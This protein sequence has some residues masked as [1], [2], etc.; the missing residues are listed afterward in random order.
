MTVSTYLFVD[1]ENLDA[2]LGMSVLGRRPDPDERPRWD[3]VLAYCDHLSSTEGE[4]GARALFFLNATSGHM[5][6]GFIQALLAMD[7]RPVPLA[8]SG[9]PEEKVVDIGIQRT[10][11]ALAAQVEAGQD[12]QVLLGSH[13]GDYIPQVER[14]LDAGARVGVLCFRE[15]LNAHLAA[16][17]ARGLTIHDLESDVDAFTIALPR[18][19]IIP[20]ADFDPV[21]FL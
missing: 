19:R 12:I 3:R 1:G 16:L 14:L 18:V 5:P 10:L 11:D 8:G 6:M 4:E 21:K 13:D 17:E 7:Y 2:T 15:F 9:L 20:L